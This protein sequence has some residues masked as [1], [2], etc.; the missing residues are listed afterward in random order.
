MQQQ[1]FANPGGLQGNEEHLQQIKMKKVEEHDSHYHYSDPSQNVS[2]IRTVPFSQTK[3]V[4][5]CKKNSV[6]LQARLH[7]VQRIKDDCYQVLLFYR[8]SCGSFSINNSAKQT[9]LNKPSY[10]QQYIL[11]KQLLLVIY[12][13]TTTTGN[14]NRARYRTYVASK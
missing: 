8:I 3:Y 10:W 6:R 7:I 2:C 5:V 13:N 4:L 12:C 14:Q 1:V 11:K 9:Y